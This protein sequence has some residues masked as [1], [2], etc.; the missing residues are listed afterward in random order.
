MGVVFR[1]R[2]TSLN[3]VVALRMILAGQLASAAD[4]QRF[5]AEAEAAAH[6]DHPHIVPIYEVGEQDGQP[7]FSMKLVEGASLGEQLPRLAREPRAAVRLLAAVARAAHHAHQRGIIHRDLKPAN[8]LVD[9]GG[10]PHVTD[11]GLARRVEGGGG[12]TQTGGIVGTPSYMAPEQAAGKKG[13]TTAADVYSLGAILCELLTG[14]PPFRAE[15][16]LDTVLQVLEKEPERPRAVN[17]Q[18]DRDLELICLKCLAKDPRQRY[19]SAEA[20][21]AE[22]ERWLA[23]APLSVRPPSPIT[24]FRFWLRQNFGAAGWIV[25]LG[26]LFGVLGGAMGLVVVVQPTLRAIAA[27]GYERLPSLQAPRVAVVWPIPLWVAA[28]VFWAMLAIGSTAGLITARLVRPKSRAADIAAGA[29]AGFLC[30]ATTFTLSMGWNFINLTALWPVQADLEL[31]SEAAVA[32]LTPPG[33][34]PDPAPKRRPRPQDR[35]LEKY[36]DLRAV[37][38]DERGRVLSQKILTDLAGG[39][40]PGIWFGALF[41][42]TVGVPV[43]TAQVVVAGPL[44]RRHGPRPMVLLPYVDESVPA[45]VLFLFA[46]SAPL[47]RYFN[48]PLRVWHLALFVLLGLALTGTRR[49]WPGPLRL[50]LHAEGCSV[51]AWW[52]R[53]GCNKSG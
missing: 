53:G 49:G 36:P 30:G 44:L 43:F 23:G 11:F 52:R 8:I 3:R 34:A 4:V 5:R 31:L 45:T 26:L 29:I 28:A 9:A 10:A 25:A 42:L 22:L 27:D 6:L 14:R 1:A 37:P 32:D 47:E 39:I 12:L 48:L 2:Q 46:Y 21:A 20:L 35:L 17:P 18:V 33:G 41:V 15:T 40:P 16:P 7:Y 24:L 50:L 38:A 13:L 51:R 19:S